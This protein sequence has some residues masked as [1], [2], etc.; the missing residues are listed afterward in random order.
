MRGSRKD[1]DECI[2]NKATVNIDQCKAIA[3][4]LAKLQINPAVNQREYLSFPLQAESKLRMFLFTIAICQQT[5][6][7]INRKLNLVGFN[8]LE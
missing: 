7:L 6:T 1:T 5:H 2:M 8:F 3:K 4:V